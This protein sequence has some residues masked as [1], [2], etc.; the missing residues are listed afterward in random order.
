MKSITQVPESR[1]PK[2]GTLLSVAV[3]VRERDKEPPRP[4][5]V[6]V[7]AKCGE[8]SAYDENLALCA[9]TAEHLEFITREMPEAFDVQRT[10]R[11]KL[12]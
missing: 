12:N 9:L 4:G 11:A 6:A 8:L 10:I 7:C 2:C 1:C 5:M 3:G